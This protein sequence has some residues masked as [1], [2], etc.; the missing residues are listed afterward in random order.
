MTN[1]AASDSGVDLTTWRE[2]L[3]DWGRTGC[4]RRRSGSDIHADHLASLRLE[5][6]ADAA[7]RFVPPSGPLGDFE[8]VR[9]IGRGGM[10]IVY[11]AHQLSV[12]RRVALKL[13]PASEWLDPQ[14]IERFAAEARAAAA[15]H[16]TNIVPV[17]SQGHEQGVHYLAMQF[18]DGISLDQLDEPSPQSTF[19]PGPASEKMVADIGRQAAEAL[20]YAHRQGVIHRDVKPANLL[21]D[22]YGT[23]W[24]SDFGLARGREDE[25]LTATGAILGTH[26]YMAPECFR[27]EADARSDVYSLGATLFELVAHEPAFETDDSPWDRQS[28]SLRSLVPG[29]SRDLQTIVARA[30]DPEPDCR[31]QSAD[32]LA[33]DLSSFLAG[34]PIQARRIGLCGRTA[35]WCYRNPALAGMTSLAALLLVA[36]TLG[37]I[38]SAEHF[39]RQAVRAREL[40]QSREVAQWARQ[41]GLDREQTVRAEAKLLRRQSERDTRRAE[42]LTRFLISEVIRDLR[43]D[44][45]LGRPLS[46]RS[47][48]DH[49]ATR[50]ESTFADQPATAASIQL[51][52][53]ESY[54]A[55]GLHLQAI[56]QLRRAV[57]NRQQALGEHHSKTHAATSL[58]A[59]AMT[60]RGL[61]TQ[62]LELHRQAYNGLRDDCGADERLVLMARHNLGL[63]LLKQCRFDESLEHTHGVLADRI[64]ID[65]TEHVCT[66]KAMNNLALCLKGLGRLEE[67]LPLS[68]DTLAVRRRILGEAHPDTLSAMHNHAQMLGLLKRHAESQA[69]YLQTLAIKRKTLGPEHPRTLNTRHNLA[70]TH[71][72]L[73]QHE[74]AEQINRDVLKIR[75]RVLGA[76]HPSTL[77]TQSN[78]GRTLLRQRRLNE[79]ETELRSAWTA[80]VSQRGESHSDTLSTKRALAR[81]RAL[82][83]RQP[84][85][86][87][88][89]TR[90]QTVRSRKVREKSKTAQEN[91]SHP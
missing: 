39:R 54:D 90:D 59:T 11:E 60:H 74:Q 22:R 26:R 61:Y 31:Y 72:R 30:M 12:D 29:I 44:R 73:G 27:G 52:L 88:V 34:E 7:E 50:V 81:C 10:G 1:A 9:E 6:A 91:A 57:K 87:F 45:R 46:P 42:A 70:I 80:Q 84:G 64:R 24:L 67:A 75:R 14:R 23:V 86:T 38:A 66:L 33:R 35:R 58:L 55:L 63:C 49:V 4:L 5:L 56:E 43:P 15:L 16:H 77:R 20:E 41:I 89:G 53:G 17:F 3:S 36:L 79:A 76:R 40:V 51:S 82:V 18:I 21:L 65:G 48:L 71:A 69:L 78:L 8:I 85:T 25:G 28:R 13:L 47:I 62:A 68:Q 37:S 19:R 32:D 83:A 2:L